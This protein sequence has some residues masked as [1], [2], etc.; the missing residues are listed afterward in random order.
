[1]NNVALA[2]YLQEARVDMM[3]TESLVSRSAGLDEGVVV[4]RHEVTYLAPL[5]FSLRPVVIESWVTDIRAA[6]FAIGYVV[7][8]ER[9]GVRTEYARASTLLAPYVF[10]SH[11]P[12]RLS[13]AEKAGLERFFE[14]SA[15]TEPVGASPAR[16]DRASAAHYPVRVRFSDVD[17][18]G[19]VNNVRY[20]EYYQEARIALLDALGRGLPPPAVVVARVEVD[21]RTQLPF[22]PEP[23]DVWSAVTR[24]GTTSYTIEAEIGD[25][26]D[27]VSRCRAVLVGYDPATG[28]PRPWSPA[29]R[30][31]LVERL[32][33]PG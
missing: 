8:D 2:D 3:R 16:L 20:L 24:V 5:T 21:Y 19:H 28:R 1:M 13:G 7:F 6:S 23:Y 27:M 10:D 11:R 14:P 32:T 22:R 33:P 30:E 4:V 26:D 29:I 12:R 31:R 25:A 15:S 17:V 18:Y 9:D